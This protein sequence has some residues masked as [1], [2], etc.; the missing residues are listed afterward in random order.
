MAGSV[1]YWKNNPDQWPVSEIEVGGVRYTKE[2]A[3]QQILNGTGP[4]ASLQLSQ[5]LIA[6]KLNHVKAA[7]RAD[8]SAALP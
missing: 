5:Q 2:A 1:Q 6:A 3:I 4:D 8:S 7:A